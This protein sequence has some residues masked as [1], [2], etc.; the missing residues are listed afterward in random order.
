VR[1]F[2]L[3]VLGLALFLSPQSVQAAEPVCSNGAVWYCLDFESGTTGLEMGWGWSN[4]TAL[5][6]LGTRSLRMDYGTAPRPGDNGGAGYGSIHRRPYRGGVSQEFHARWYEYLTPGWTWSPI[7]TKGFIVQAVNGQNY[8]K[9]Y[10]LNA[11]WNGV[12]MLYVQRGDRTYPPNVL[13]RPFPTG[14]WVQV[15]IH[16][17]AQTGV[18]REWQ[19]GVLVSN[20]SGI[21]FGDVANGGGYHGL[22]ISA[23]WNCT[24]S[25][26]LNN[27]HG[28][29]SRYIDNLV[30]ADG[31]V[32]IGPA[33]STGGGTVTPPP[34]TASTP[35]SA[36]TNLVVR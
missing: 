26:C 19:D 1:V 28:P 2:A 7:A 22:E 8:W 35:P 9:L 29:Q 5:R 10:I 17:N 13:S 18:Y 31:N 4:S 3:A 11:V 36:P 24:A 33:G 27:T 15:E 21:P 12:R 23:Y 25:N 32:M 6:Y 34:P 14:R 30:I 20:Y 16:V